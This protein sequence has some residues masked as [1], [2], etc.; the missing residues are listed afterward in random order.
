MNLYRA[1]FVPVSMDPNGEK[2]VC[3]KFAT[4]FFIPRVRTRTW[5]QT[6]ETG[7]GEKAIDACKRVA[8]GTGSLINSA[9]IVVGVNKWGCH[10][11]LNY[12]R[13]CGPGR[14]ADGNQCAFIDYIRRFGIDGRFLIN[15]PPIDDVDYCCFMHDCCLGGFWEYVVQNVHYKCNAEFLRCLGRA[16]CSKSP[17]RSDCRG[18][19]RKARSLTIVTLGCPFRFP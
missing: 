15:P 11:L 4:V 17:A 10:T 8:K 2:E 5:E 1:Y 18:F 19:R 3:C 16:N 9:W 6:V 14:M 7:P 12:G 13:Y